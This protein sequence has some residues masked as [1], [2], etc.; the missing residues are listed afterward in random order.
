M[1]KIN[2]IVP[3]IARTGGMRII[4]EYANRLTEKGH[5]VMLYSPNVPFNNYKGMFVP[6]YI[7]YRTKYAL[8]KIFSGKKLPSRIFEHSFGIKHL[9]SMNNGSIRDAD[10][11]VATSWTSS[12]VAERLSS[13]KGKKVYLIQDYETWNSNVELVNKSYSLPFERVTVS[14]YLHDLLLKKFGSSSAVILNGIDFEKFNNPEKKFGDN[15][16]ILFMDHILENKNTKGAIEVVSRLRQKFNTIKFKCFGFENFH[17]L[18]EFIRFIR[19]PSEEEIVNLYR[20][21]DIFLYTAFYE[22]FALPPAEAMACKCAVVGSN[23]AALPEY[24]INNQT[25]LLTTPG[26]LDEITDRV[27]FLLNNR[28]ELERI[29]TAGYEHVRRILNWDDSVNKFEKILFS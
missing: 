17:S 10:A 11:T 4:F 8:K 9:W 14:R 21:S 12:Y 13:S 23:T 27:E 15:P 26:N 24:S 2:F 20:N 25:A 3:E 18:P 19:N 5:D 6:F 28:S 16:Q 22:G 29:S 7:K 1:S